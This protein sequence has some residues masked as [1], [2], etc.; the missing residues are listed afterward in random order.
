MG[1]YI[2]DRLPDPIS[3]FDAEDVR[4]IGP[5]RW[6]T[7]PCNFHGGSDSL[8]VNTAS[9]GWCCMACGA[10]GGD[11]LAYHMQM[12]GMEFVEAATAL[13]AYVDDGRRYSGKMTATTLSARDAMQV[14]AHELLVLLIVIADIRAG[15]IPKDADWQRFVVGAGRVETLAREFAP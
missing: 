14:I 1:E 9:G 3:Y 13:G 6:K 7:G 15:V 2:R 10:K 5:G 4:L 8:R 12:H 11:V